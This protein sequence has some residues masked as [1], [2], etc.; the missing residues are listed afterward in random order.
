MKMMDRTHARR[1]LKVAEKCLGE[2]PSRELDGIIYC[3]LFELE[4]LNDLSNARHHGS[5]STGEVLVQAN[6]GFS[7]AWFRVP[8]Y[9]SNKDDA[10]TLYPTHVDIVPDNLSSACAT[11]L[12]ARVAIGAPTP[13]FLSVVRDNIGE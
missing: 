3:A 5:R 7:A 6:K 8:C 11:A 9:T 4:D 13:V 12:R 1:L 10:R 2:P